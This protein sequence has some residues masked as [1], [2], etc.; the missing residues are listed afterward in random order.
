MPLNKETKPS[1]FRIFLFFKRLI[2]KIIRKKWKTNVLI[3]L[4]LN[5]LKS[6]FR[7]ICKSPKNKVSAEY[8]LFFSLF[9]SGIYKLIITSKL[10]VP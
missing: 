1:F 2:T 3:N 8:N 5:C 9:Y 7:F 6:M 10:L 4:Q